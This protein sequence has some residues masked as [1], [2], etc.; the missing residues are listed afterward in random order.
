M[1]NDFDHNAPSYNDDNKPNNQNDWKSLHDALHD[2]DDFETDAEEGLQHINKEALPTI[3]A[4]L[5]TQ[6]HQQIKKKKNINKKKL[7]DQTST[8]ITIITILI[9]VVVAYIVIK[10]LLP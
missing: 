10:K 1:N 6:L 3:V 7:M 5:N 9:L 8:Y 4:Q 2:N